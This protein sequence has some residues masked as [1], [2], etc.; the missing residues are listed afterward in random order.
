[1]DFDFEEDEV[2]EEPVEEALSKV[3]Q[4]YLSRRKTMTKEEFAERLEAEDEILIFTGDPREAGIRG[5]GYF[6]AQVDGKY[7]V[8][9]WDETYEDDF[10]DSEVAET[11]DTIDELWA[12]MVD[13]MEDDDFNPEY[14]YLAEA[15]A[16]KPIPEGMTIEQLQEEIEENEDTVECS[17]CGNLVEKANCHHNQEGFGWCC[18]TCEPADTLVEEYNL[19]DLV[20]DSINH[21]VNDL[22]KD[23]WAD[24]FGDDVVKDIENNYENEAPTDLAKYNSWANSIMSEVSRQVNRDYQLNKEAE[25]EE[26]HDLGNTYDGG[27]PDNA[28]N[29]DFP[30]V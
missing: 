24:D 18:N 2:P 14:N 13:F 28:F 6:A 5:R 29:L 4:D 16:K 26:L 3:Q 23:P 11:F 1:M 12:Y 19:A 17:K 27:Y 20:A 30:E 15:C 8:S 25:P 9:F 22:G 10:T 21:L 7:E